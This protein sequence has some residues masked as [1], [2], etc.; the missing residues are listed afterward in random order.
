PRVVRSGS[1]DNDTRRLQETVQSLV[2][3][4]DRLLAR[5]A[6]LERSLEDI[7]GSFPPRSGAVPPDDAA[8]IELETVPEPTPVTAGPPAP[9][10]GKNATA[11]PKM[12]PDAPPVTAIVVP[13][14]LPRPFPMPKKEPVVQVEPE[15]PA[16]E[17]GID[18]GSATGFDG[19]R[20]L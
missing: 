10:E 12:P 3:D 14:P 1:G 18:V 4:R 2:A 9:P 15:I 8:P 20:L 6:M 7:T 17:S 19:L 5:I 11:G 13:I 16:P